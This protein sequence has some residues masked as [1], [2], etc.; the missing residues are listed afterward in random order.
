MDPAYSHSFTRKHLFRRSLN[1][2]GAN[3][4]TRTNL[5]S[6]DNRA[7]LLSSTSTLEASA[8]KD[9]HHGILAAADVDSLKSNPE[10]S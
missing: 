1:A 8:D 2:L 10:G 4:L 3:V 6:A 9:A 7:A 5:A